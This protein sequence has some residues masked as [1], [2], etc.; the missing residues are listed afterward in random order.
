MTL[1]GFLGQIFV[2]GQKYMKL[3]DII[4]GLKQ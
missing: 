3:L 1:I 4:D 2:C